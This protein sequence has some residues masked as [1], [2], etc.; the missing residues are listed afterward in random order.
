MALHGGAGATRRNHYAR[1]CANMLG[2]VETGRDALRH[3]ASAVDVAVG[4]VQAMEA[5]AL[6][7]AG[8]GSWPNLDGQY[9]LDASVMEGR[10][11]RAGAVAALQGFR[12]PI[13]IARAIM[14]RTPHVLVV[15][16]GAA[17]IADSL[18]QTRID[19]TATWFIP[20]AAGESNHGPA[21][22]TSTVGCVVLD[23]D[24]HLA[25]AT[26]SGGVFH[27]VPGRLGDSPIIGAGTWADSRAA[28]SCTGQGEYFLRSAAAAQVAFRIELGETLAQ[29]CATVLA[30][31][32]RL[33]G[34]G[35][36]IAV[37]AHGDIATPYYAEG[38]KRATLSRDGEMR[39]LV[40]DS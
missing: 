23:A 40:F 14:E 35:G 9:E 22:T 15:G 26:S 8:R 33:G 25:A 29:A 19:D 37:T 20:A 39:A 34:E 36:L 21:R 32:E 10:T 16:Q 7:V 30:Q 38:M 1:E 4:T 2:L 3:G 6:Y 11:R 12:S 5:S 31:I 27:K 13:G 18:Q 17:A 24:G 28:V